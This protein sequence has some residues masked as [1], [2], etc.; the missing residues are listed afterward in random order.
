MGNEAKEISITSTINSLLVYK[1]IYMVR[2][3]C[4]TYFV[5]VGIINHQ[6]EQAHQK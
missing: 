6:W 3:S 4:E 5:F 2:P 1:N